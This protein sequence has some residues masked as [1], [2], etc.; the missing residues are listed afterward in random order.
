MAF[1]KSKID[2]NVSR[3]KSLPKNDAFDSQDTK[4]YVTT[5]LRLALYQVIKKERD[6]MMTSQ[7]RV[8]KI[9]KV[10]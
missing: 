1:I 6:Q 3:K 2:E 7:E 4:P 5:M 8:L 9:S 10:I